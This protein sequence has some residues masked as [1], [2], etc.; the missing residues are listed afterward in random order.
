MGG[1]GRSMS[2]VAGRDATIGTG[3]DGLDEIVCG[4]LPTG[5]VYLVRGAP[6][7]G[8]TTLALQ[9]L[10][11]GV[12]QR[13]AALYLALGETPSELAAVARSHGWSLEGIDICDLHNTEH[14]EK[15]GEYTFF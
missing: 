1:R 5:N 10:L 2:S 15:G 11:A 12:R 6:G 8:K 9:F 7:T 3:V 14:V 13:E 4:G